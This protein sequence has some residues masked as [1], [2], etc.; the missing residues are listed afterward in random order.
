MQEG[1]IFTV[2]IR[3][4]VLRALG[5]IQNS[6]QV[7]NFSTC[8]LN[9]GVLFCQQFQIL[10]FK[11]SKCFFGSHVHPPFLTFRRTR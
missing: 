6:L 7:N 3:N 4:E 8:G 5:K 2:N 10:Q 11:G 9:R 1:F